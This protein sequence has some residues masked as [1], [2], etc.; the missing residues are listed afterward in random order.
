V[1]FRCVAADCFIFLLVFGAYG[2]L[3]RRRSVILETSLD[4][5][6]SEWPAALFHVLFI[7]WASV[8]FERAA[9]PKTFLA[10]RDPGAGPRDEAARETVDFVTLSTPP[11]RPACIVVAFLILTFCPPPAVAVTPRG[12]PISWLSVALIVFLVRRL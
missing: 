10:V 4:L 7:R 11:R 2:D 3:L 5:T 1:A 6:R 12:N 8:S 9:N